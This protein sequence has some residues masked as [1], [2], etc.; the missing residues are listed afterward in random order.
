[1]PDM[2]TESGTDELIEAVGRNPEIC[3]KESHYDEKLV[4]LNRAITD[5]VALHAQLHASINH[6]CEAWKIARIDKLTAVPVGFRQIMDELVVSQDNHN[7][8]KEKR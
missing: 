6:I 2:D 5:Q 7:A 8:S 1:M 3:K 4:T